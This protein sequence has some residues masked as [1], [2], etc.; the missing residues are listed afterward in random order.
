MQSNACKRL[1]TLPVWIAA[2][3]LGCGPQREFKNIDAHWQIMWEHSQIAEAGGRHP[4]LWRNSVNVHVA[5]DRDTY[6]YRVVGGDCVVWKGLDSRG[7]YIACSDH[8]PVLMAKAEYADDLVVSG[9]TVALS[10]FGKP[11]FQ[12]SLRQWKERTRH[13]RA[14]TNGWRADLLDALAPEAQSN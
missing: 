8:Q 1:I 3:T 4:F 2:L 10:E 13:Q 12:G 14:L 9:D 5:V 11:Y 6:E 7:P